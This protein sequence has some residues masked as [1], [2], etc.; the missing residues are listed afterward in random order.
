MGAL[1]VAD[2][3]AQVS[4]N[5]ATDFVNYTE[6]KPGDYQHTALT[7]TLDQLVAWSTALAPLRGR[8]SRLIT[9]HRPTSR[10]SPR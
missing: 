2:V 9:R 8:R 4:L 10:D 3:A 7:M 1:Q 6:C 5:L